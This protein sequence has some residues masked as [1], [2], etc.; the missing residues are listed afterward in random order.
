MRRHAPRVDCRFGADG[1]WA[2]RASIAV[3]YEQFYTAALIPG[4]SPGGRRE[5]SPEFFSP[6]T[7]QRRLRL[8]Y[9]A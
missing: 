8:A 1:G 6:L 2:E 7:T 5:N 9:H 4:P 3:S